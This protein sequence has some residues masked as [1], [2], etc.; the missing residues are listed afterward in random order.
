MAVVAVAVEFQQHRTFALGDDRLGAGNGVAD[1]HRVHTV[2]DFGVHIVVVKTGGTAGK[3]IQTVDFAIGAAGHTK[4]VVDD[5]E[6]QRQTELGLGQRPVELIL[7][8]P[9]QSFQYHTVGVSAVTGKGGDHAT[10]IGRVDTAGHG[11]TGSDRNT[12]AD[13]GVGAQVTDAEVSNV[14]PAAAT[15]AVTVFLTEKFGDGA[16][17]VIFHDCIAQF[18]ALECGVFGAAFAHIFFAHVLDGVETLGDTV[19]VAAV[20]GGDKVGDVQHAAHPGGGRFLTDGEVGRAAVV[21]VADDLVS[22][23]TALEDHFFKLADGQHGLI[24]FQHFGFGDFLCLVFSGNA[25]IVLISRNAV[26]FDG[27]LLETR[28]GITV[29]IVAH[30]SFFLCFF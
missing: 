8:G 4:V 16:E 29:V 9:V 5:D 27:R 15:F 17:N 19:A 11:R 13:D 24:D 23:G 12:A 26:Q 28:S 2:D 7:S 18:F 3:V 20:G 22:T 1:C 10:L 6:D 25:R 21:V 30:F 14:H